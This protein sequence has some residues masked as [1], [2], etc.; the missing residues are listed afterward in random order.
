MSKTR[1]TFTA[2][3]VLVVGSIHCDKKPEPIANTSESIGAK[4]APAP[5]SS[6]TDASP[7]A[8]S[9]RAKDAGPAPETWYACR[10]ADDCTMVPEGDCC[11]AC[12]PLIF[13]GYTAVNAKHKDDFLAHEGCNTVTCPKCPPL[14]PQ[15]PRSS[16]NFFVLC[17]KGRCVATDL[18]MSKYTE[19]KSDDDCKMRWG[20]R[21]CDGCSDSELVAYNPAS[22]LLSDICPPKKP[23]CP[24]VTPA[25]AADRSPRDHAYCVG[26]YCQLSD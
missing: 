7:V 9:T 16:S 12:D 4:N 15:V 20:L 18:R 3:L 24:P 17:Q 5:A 23:Q 13:A 6:T 14:S 22:S 10:K 11:P 19:C 1:R 2:I 8:P 25:C 21:C 26:G